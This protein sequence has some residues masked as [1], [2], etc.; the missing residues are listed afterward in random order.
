M[1]NTKDLNS[2]KKIIVCHISSMHNNWADD[3]IYE[4]A[5]LGLKRE[6]LDVHLVF[7]KP[8]VIPPGEGV[9]FHWIKKRKG[10]KRRWLSSKEAVSKAIE[11]KADIYHFHD[12]DLLPHILKI[13]KRIPQAKVVFDIHEN[14]QARFSQ[15]GLPV[16]LG[17]IYQRYQLRKMNLLDGFATT[18]ETMMSL[19]SNVRKPGVVIRNSVDVY[20]LSHVDLANIQPFDIPTIYTSGSQ[21][22]SRLVLQCVQSM[23]HISKDLNFRMMFAGRYSPGIREELKEQAEKDGTG[24]LLQLEGM[25]PWDENFSRTAKAFCGCVFYENNQNNQVTLPN[26]IYEYM[27]SGIPIVV[28]DYPELRNIV[29]KAKCGLIVPSDKPED[30]A[31]AFEFLLQNPEKAKAMGR[32]G[33]KAIFEDFGYHVD[34]KNTLEFYNQILNS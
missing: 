26:R 20:R 3:R 8:D 11:I 28:S 34:I 27:F 1:R 18:T 23:R 31:K 29:E 33:R 2:E 5:C 25:L 14:Y 12:P 7:T 24:Q 17:K 32:N 16:F 21:S 6:G 13:K 30:M 15:W 4:R 9:H 19:F 10:W 22:H